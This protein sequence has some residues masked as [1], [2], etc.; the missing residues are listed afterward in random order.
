MID[1]W[2]K[3]VPFLLQT[4]LRHSMI[5]V[6]IP[7]KTAMMNTGDMKTTLTAKTL[8]MESEQ[9]TLGFWNLL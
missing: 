6:Y 1:N 3:L 4:T 2:C 7:S 8:M 5:D 9:R